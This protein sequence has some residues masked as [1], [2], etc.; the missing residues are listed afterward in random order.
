MHALKYQK[1]TQLCVPCHFI[2]FHVTLGHLFVFVWWIDE[3]LKLHIKCIQMQMGNELS[4]HY[5]NGWP[6]YETHANLNNIMDSSMHVLKYKKAT[7]LCVP[8]H[9]ISFHVALG[10]LYVSVRWIDEWFKL[11]VKYI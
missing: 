10:H 7:Q 2:S 11:Y 6:F 4:R 1:A 9:F 3:C 5:R 8:C